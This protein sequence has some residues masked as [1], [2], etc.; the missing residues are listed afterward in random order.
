MPRAVCP[1]LLD[2]HSLQTGGDCDLGPP[3]AVSE[4]QFTMIL[5]FLFVLPQR[6]RSRSVLIDYQFAS[7]WGSHRI[8]MVAIE[9]FHGIALGSPCW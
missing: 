2:R 5:S 4:P 6:E 1:M 9:L 3:H 8:A 7:D